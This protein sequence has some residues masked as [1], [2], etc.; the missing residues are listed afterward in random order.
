MDPV[1]GLLGVNAD[2]KLEP[3]TDFNY[4][5][6]DANVFGVVEQDDV[7]EFGDEL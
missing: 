1:H 6:I 5:E 2:G 3:T 7:V 4:S